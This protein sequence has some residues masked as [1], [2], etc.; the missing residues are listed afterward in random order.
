LWAAMWAALAVAGCDAFGPESPLPPGAQ[1]LDLSTGQLSAD[2]QAWWSKTEA[3]AGIQGRFAEVQ[4]FVVPGVETFPTD[5]GEK[6][7]L[8][9]RGRSGVRIVIAGLYVD[10]ELVVSHE[11]LHDLLGR[12]GHPDEYFKNRC[13]LTWDTF[14]A[15][16][17]GNLASR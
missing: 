13:H 15:P 7:G 2:Y 5:M 1:P 4:W 6:V 10:N 3:C 9:T 8:W 16:R 17:T 12:E 14:G 11:I